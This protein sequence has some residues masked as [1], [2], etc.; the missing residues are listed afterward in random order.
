VVVGDGAFVVAV[1]YFV[2]RTHL[3]AFLML[4]LINLPIKVGG[5]GRGISFFSTAARCPRR[6]RLDAE[7]GSDS[8]KDSRVGTIGHALLEAFYNGQIAKELIDDPNVVVQVPNE[9]EEEVPEALRM[10]RAYLAKFPERDFWGTPVGTEVSFPQPGKEEIVRSF[11]MVA[12]TAR[13]DLVT[14][15]SESEEQQQRIRSRLCLDVPTGLVIIDHKFR[16]RKDYSIQDTYDLS[17]Q[18]TA[19]P[20][21]WDLHHPDQPCQGMIANVV[22]GTKEVGIQHTVVRPP[23]ETKLIGLRNWLIGADAMSGT[24]WPNWV[25]CKD[26]NRTCPHFTSG[27]CDRT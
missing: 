23:D 5:S 27:R 10:V 19:Y 20:P 15:I 16:T 1:A 2:C 12:L 14:N 9:F 11:F 7:H 24:D 4:N 3:E 22:I 18:F 26:F 21:L 17:A 25:S 8:S 13:L 6:A